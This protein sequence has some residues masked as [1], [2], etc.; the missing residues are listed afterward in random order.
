VRGTEKLG[1]SMKHTLV[2]EDSLSASLRLPKYTA[3]MPEPKTEKARKRAAFFM[4]P[5][6][7][8]LAP[9]GDVGFGT[10]SELDCQNGNLDLE[11]MFEPMR[12]RRIWA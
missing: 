3:L 2:T 11:L 6:E 12:N 5:I 8:N 4:R 1:R 9:A 10:D 7:W